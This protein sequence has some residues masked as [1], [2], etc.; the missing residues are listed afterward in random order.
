MQSLRDDDAGFFALEFV[1]AGELAA[2][3]FEEAAGARASV[4][5][6][7]A[8]AIEKNEKLEDFG[9]FGV[10]L[11]ILR[12]GLL[13]FVEERGKSVVE[14]ALDGRNRRLLLD[15]AG[16]KRFIGFGKRL[17]GG[18]DVG[19]G[20]GGLRGAE[21]GNGKG[22]GGDQL[23]MNEDEIRSEAD[24][25]QGRIRRKLARV[26]FFVAMGGQEISTVGRTIEGDFP[27]G[28]AADGADFFGLGRAEARG[29]A[30]LTDRTGQGIP[31]EQS[32]EP[33]APASDPST[34]LRASGGRYKS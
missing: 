20:R 3:K 13:G 10:A 29:L 9:I 11:R 12:G 6:Q 28:A 14:S 27:F 33:K 26:L 32:I 1:G 30:F 4:G 31:L 7:Q 34:T 25:Q 16:G 21:F 5:A 24:I 18:E 17:Q 22:D 19:V 8:H 23:G 2:E 15:D